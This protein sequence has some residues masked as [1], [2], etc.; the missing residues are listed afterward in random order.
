MK[1]C[2]SCE[3]WVV[4]EHEKKMSR[5]MSGLTVIVHGHYEYQF[6]CDE[7]FEAIGNHCC[8]YIESKK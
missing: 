2:I 7:I 8:L 3:N 4:C 6:M 1:S 5:A